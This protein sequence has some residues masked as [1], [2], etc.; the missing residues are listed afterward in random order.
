[1]YFWWGKKELRVV[2]KELRVVLLKEL[3][4]FLVRKKKILTKFIFRSSFK[5][6]T[7]SSKRTTGSSKRTTM[8]FW[9]EKKELRVVPK[10]LRVVPKE[11]LCIFSGKK[12]N[13]G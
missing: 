11:L 9:W 3:R 4:F 6:T 2:P 8:Y 12:K 1:M 10:E 5:R 7:R 13:Y